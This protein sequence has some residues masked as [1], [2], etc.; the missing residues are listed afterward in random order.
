MGTLIGLIQQIFMDF[1]RKISK[2]PFNQSNQFS[3]F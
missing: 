3:Y 1:E 2:N